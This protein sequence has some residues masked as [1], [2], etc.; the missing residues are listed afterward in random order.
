[1]ASEEP[2]NQSHFISTN[3]A[4]KSKLSVESEANIREHRLALTS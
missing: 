2:A 3:I 1:M 4:Y